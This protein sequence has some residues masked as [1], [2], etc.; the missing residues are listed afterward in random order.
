[1]LKAKG[2]ARAVSEVSQMIDLAR[3][4]AMAKSTYVWLGFYAGAQ[5]GSS[6]LQMVAARSI[7]GTPNLK[8][9]GRINYRLVGKVQK[10]DRILLTDATGLTQTVRTMLSDAA[11]TPSAIEI[12][13]LKATPD[14]LAAPVNG[15][16][17]NFV[18]LIT[19]TPQGEALATNTPST[20][21]P[22]APFTTQML[23]SLRN[24]AGMNAVPS[25]VDSAGLVLYGGTGQIRVFRP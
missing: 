16:S 11:V 3:T 14:S 1:L 7:D 9:G 22:P 25:D 15:G 17:V 10:L 20:A 5:D 23:V 19:F 6:Q 2:L 24:A 8:V 18:S 4:E 21:T 12:A 13:T